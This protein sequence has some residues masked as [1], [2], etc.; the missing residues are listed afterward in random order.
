VSGPAS[1][2][3]VAGGTSIA[4]GGF[5]IDGTIIENGAMIPIEIS[6]SAPGASM[7]TMSQT[8]V[9][10]VYWLG[11]NMPV[12]LKPMTLSVTVQLGDEADYWA[13]REAKDRG[14]VV[15]LWFDWPMTDWWYVPGGEDT[16]TEWRVSRP[17]PY[18]KVTGITQATRPPKVWIDDVSQTVN[19]TGSASSGVV[20]LA[21]TDGYENLETIALAADT[22]TWIKLRYHP[23]ILVSIEEMSEVH[24]RHNDI[25]LQVDLVEHFGGIYYL[26]GGGGL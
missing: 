18:G 16:V 15:E 13:V 3:D 2:P 5:Y 19:T 7:T 22:Y 4:A 25:V 9:R 17:L 1:W 20:V 11:G 8:T 21:D 10:Q 23:M 14:N 6:S 26:A 12:N 24:A